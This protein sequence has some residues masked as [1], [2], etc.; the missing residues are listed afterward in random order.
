MQRGQR[1]V[2]ALN[3]IGEARALDF[4]KMRFARE[5]RNHVAAIGAGSEFLAVKK[6]ADIRR[7]ANNNGFHAPEV[8]AAERTEHNHQQQDQYNNAEP[9]AA[10][11]FFLRI[12][13]LSRIRRRN[14]LRLWL[15][16]WRSDLG[17]R[18]GRSCR[19]NS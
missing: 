4:E 2:E 19:L 14:G 11:L 7:A 16:G 3:G 17:L 5:M 8:P 15:S 13:K 9:A 10:W 1:E 18:C 12:S 6:Y